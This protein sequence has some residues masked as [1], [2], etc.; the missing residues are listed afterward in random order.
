MWLLD[1]SYPNK[2][3]Q[4]NTQ[5]DKHQ[6]CGPLVLDNF[7]LIPMDVLIWV[8]LRILG[9][10]PQKKTMVYHHVPSFSLFYGLSSK[11]NSIVIGETIVK[12]E[13]CD[14]QLSY[15][16]RGPLI[17]GQNGHHSFE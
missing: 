11:H 1:D 9:N 6:I 2:D 8:C 4:D 5:V 7:W 13:L 15:R 17:V 3:G 16:K 12:L 14:P 10:M